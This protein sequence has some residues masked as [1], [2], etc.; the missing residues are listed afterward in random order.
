MLSDIFL[1]YCTTS[2]SIYKKKKFFLNIL[3]K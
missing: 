3:N 2:G 1:N